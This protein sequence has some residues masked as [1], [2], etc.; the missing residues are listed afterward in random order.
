MPLLGSTRAE[1]ACH[2]IHPIKKKQYAIIFPSAFLHYLV[3][4]FQFTINNNGTLTNT[5][6]LR[7]IFK[8][9]VVDTVHHPWLGNIESLKIEDSYITALEAFLWTSDCPKFIAMAILLK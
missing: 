1:P 2:P 3:F 4:T 5:T 8:R 6:S 9:Q 7:I